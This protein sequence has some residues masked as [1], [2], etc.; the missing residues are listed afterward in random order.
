MAKRFHDT[1]IW[2]Q[3]W[4]ISCPVEYQHLWFYIK[5]SCD[6]AGVW[7]PEKMMYELLTKT[8]IDL[9]IA[10]QYYN[11]LK[12]RIKI[13]PNGRWLI[14]D[15][16]SFQYGKHLSV[17]NRFHSS[18][19]KALDGNEVELTSIR[20]L[21]DLNE[22]CKDK[23]KDNTLGVD[24]KEGPREGLHLAQEVWFEELWKEYPA[25]GRIR[26]KEASR[27]FCGSVKNET[28]FDRCKLSLARY[29]ESKRVREGVVQNASTWFNDWE[30]WENFTEESQ[31]SAVPEMMR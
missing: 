14:P 25:S 9:E 17:D 1:E 4:F 19:L 24:V 3:E 16:I 10:L 15:F 20:G 11:R 30:S 13:L 31:V 29:I 2:V 22:T 27:R 23:D 7:K 5:D 8:A 28:D 21:K 18:I 12:N 6:H 26:K